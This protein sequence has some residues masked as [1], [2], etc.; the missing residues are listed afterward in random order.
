M[1]IPTQLD[2]YIF[3]LILHCMKNSLFPNI[4]EPIF[5]TFQ[6]IP[7]RHRYLLPGNI[8]LLFILSV[9][10]SHLTTSMY[11]LSVLLHDFI[12]IIMA[13][14]AV[15]LRGWLPHRGKAQMACNYCFPTRTMFYINSEF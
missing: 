4:F 2:L 5:Q 9:V 7:F 3:S 1:S 15:F 11:M 13:G 6:K 8:K 14:M 12:I 10:V